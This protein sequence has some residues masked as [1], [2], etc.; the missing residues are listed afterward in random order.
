MFEM[1]GGECRGRIINQLS[2]GKVRGKIFGEEVV[3]LIDRGA[4]HTFISNKVVNDLKLST[5][6][7]SH[8]GVILGSSI[9]IKGKGV[10]ENVELL[11]NDWNVT[12][13]FLP[14]ELG[15]V[16]VILGMQWH[17]HWGLRKWIGKI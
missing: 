16:D 2:G 11:L 3:V 5:K 17:T 7:T 12:T 9:A 15:G 6:E 4:T 10:C 13:D 14:L 8:Y 1:E